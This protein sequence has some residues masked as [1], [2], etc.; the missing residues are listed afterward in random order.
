MRIIFDVEALDDLRRIRTWVAKENPRA[1]DE[2]IARIF[3]R[4]EFLLEPELTYMGRPGL[5]AG[6]H[7]LVEN[8]YIIV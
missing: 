3:D 6:T 8:P 5:D 1:A 7:E 2:L 4:I